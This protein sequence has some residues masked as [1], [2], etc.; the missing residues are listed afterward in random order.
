M[1]S[2]KQRDDIA[3]MRGLSLAALIT[4]FVGL[5]LLGLTMD[6]RGGVGW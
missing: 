4:V 6:C 3:R 1:M 2:Q 5:A